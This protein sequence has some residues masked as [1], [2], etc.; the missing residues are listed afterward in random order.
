MYI[1]GKSER[2][3]GSLSSVGLEKQEDKDM[4]TVDRTRYPDPID[5]LQIGLTCYLLQHSVQCS[6]VR[7]D[8]TRQVYLE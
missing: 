5:T 2:G 1:V 4:Y 6:I 8:K 3:L 7:Q